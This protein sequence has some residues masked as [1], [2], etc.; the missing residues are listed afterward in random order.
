[1][2]NP[3][4]QQNKLLPYSGPLPFSHNYRVE[5]KFI[6]ARKLLSSIDQLTCWREL[7]NQPVDL[8]DFIKNPFRDDKTPRCFLSEYKGNIVLSDWGAKEFNGMSLIEAI[9]R[10][11]RCSYYDALRML[12]NKQRLPGVHPSGAIPHQEH[13]KFIFKV[14]V[15]PYTDSGGSFTFLPKDGDYWKKRHISSNDLLEDQ[16]YSLHS[17]TCNS[18]KEPNTFKTH[19]NRTLT[20][21]FTVNGKYKIYKPLEKIFISQLSERD[22]GQLDNLPLSDHTL[23]ITKSYKDCRI[24]RNLGYNAIW[25][26]GESMAIAI[27]IARN[28]VQRFDYIVVFYDNDNAGI[29]GANMNVGILNSIK[30]GIAEAKHILPENLKDPDEYIV[31]EGI[32]SLM[33]HLELIMPNARRRS[34]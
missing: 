30:P 16:T 8:G 7:L 13:T 31:S 11:E 15:R 6:D 5:N 1:M 24:L 32:H 9:K 10:S 20:Y 33:N 23:I 28:L 14:N 12:N 26:Q 25:M 22:I 34:K 27:D 21:C 17:Y 2:T 18:K 3:L 29:K 4:N 19:I